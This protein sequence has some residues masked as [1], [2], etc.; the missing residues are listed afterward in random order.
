MVMSEYSPQFNYDPE[1]LQQFHATASLE[2]L[3]LAAAQR[4]Q[5]QVLRETVTPEDRMVA[6]DPTLSQK[7]ALTALG[8]VEH[9]VAGFGEGAAQTVQELLGSPANRYTLAA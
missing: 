8:S 5:R 6:F 1:T 2:E 7:L 4:F 9:G 3:R